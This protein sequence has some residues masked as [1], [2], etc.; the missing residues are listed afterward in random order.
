MKKGLSIIC[1][2]LI[3]V[4]MVSLAACGS[5]NLDGTY[6]LVQVIRDGEDI[7]E[8]SLSQFADDNIPLLTISGNEAVTPMDGYHETTFV[9][10]F[11]AKT[12]TASS[13]PVV[14]YSVSGNK[15]TLDSNDGFIQTYKKI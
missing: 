4:M 6:K 7:T 11:E 8:A 1:V 9:I 15:I 2:C 5:D 14:N 13:G 10:D 3:A 12:M